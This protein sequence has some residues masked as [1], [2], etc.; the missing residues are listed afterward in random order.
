MSI[1]MSGCEASNWL[2]RLFNVTVSWSFIVCQKV[3][4]VAWDRAFAVAASVAAAIAAAT[5]SAS[6]E[7][8]RPMRCILVSSLL[9]L[10]A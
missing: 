10:R 8:R 7:A 5:A 1:L 9:G 2:T 3:M 4:V 6:S